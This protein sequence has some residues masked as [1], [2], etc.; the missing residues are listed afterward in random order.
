MQ[1][2]ILSLMQMAKISAALAR[3]DQAGGL[4]ISDLDQSDDG[5]RGGQLR[6]CRATSR[7]PS[8]AP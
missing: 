2:G 1:E 6:A 8:R 5:R 7:W 4:Y 3:Y